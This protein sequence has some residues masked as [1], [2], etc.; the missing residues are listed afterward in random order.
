M[1]VYVSVMK[2]NMY[3]FLVVVLLIH[4]HKVTQT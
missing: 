4:H 2:A 3:V 1:L